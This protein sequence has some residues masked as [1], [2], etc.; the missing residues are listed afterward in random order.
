MSKATQAIMHE[1]AP[2]GAVTV[3]FK[4]TKSTLRFNAGGSNEGWWWRGYPIKL[5][6][7]VEITDEYTVRAVV[8][9]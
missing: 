4:E 5:T 1:A 9:S 7:A 6:R 8:K 3:F 2:T